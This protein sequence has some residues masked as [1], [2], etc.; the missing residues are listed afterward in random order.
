MWKIHLFYNSE[1]RSVLNRSSKRDTKFNLKRISS[2]QC[3]LIAHCWFK[4]LCLDFHAAYITVVS[5]WNILVYVADKKVHLANVNNEALSKIKKIMAPGSVLRCKG[6]AVFAKT[7]NLRIDYTGHLAGKIN[8]LNQ[9]SNWP[10][11][12]FDHILTIH[13]D[14]IHKS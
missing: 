2:Q 8:S 14:L 4:V 6:G 10:P 5:D 9:K 3:S 12:T 13:K 1:P 7:Y 11:Y